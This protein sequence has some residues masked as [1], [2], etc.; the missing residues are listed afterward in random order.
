MPLSGCPSIVCLD[1][2]EAEAP[3]LAEVQQLGAR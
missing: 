2:I 1:H 3:L